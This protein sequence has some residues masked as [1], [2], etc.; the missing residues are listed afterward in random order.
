MDKCCRTCKH[1]RSELCEHE[2]LMIDVKDII[3]DIFLEMK[4]DAR[5][6]YLREVV[7]G[8]EEAVLSRVENV[9]FAPPDI[10]E[11][12]CKYYE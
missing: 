9:K 11:F 4:V 12:Y 1:C 5:E 7:C 6:S 10:R 2:N 8:F 3:D